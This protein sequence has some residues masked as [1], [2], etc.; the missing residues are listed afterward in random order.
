MAKVSLLRVVWLTCSSFSRFNFPKWLFLVPPLIVRIGNMIKGRLQNLVEMKLRV[1]TMSIWW[2]RTINFKERIGRGFSH[3]TYSY[4]IVQGLCEGSLSSVL[5]FSDVLELTTASNCEEGARRQ[6]SACSG[7]AGVHSQNLR[8]YLHSWMISV[9][10]IFVFPDS[11]KQ[12]KLVFWDRVV[13]YGFLKTL[14]FAVHTCFFFWAGMFV[15]PFLVLVVFRFSTTEE[16]RQ[17]WI[18]AV[19]RSKWHPTKYP[20]LRSDHLLSIDYKVP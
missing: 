14:I 5:G 20:Y 18:S 11:S 1:K 7:V 6:S 8:S 4:L 13:L 12:H 2:K 17:L 3:F 9:C 16:R 15:K 19:R 10:K